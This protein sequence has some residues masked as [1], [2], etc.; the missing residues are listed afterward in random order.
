MG[1]FLEASLQKGFVSAQL[2]FHEFSS[3]VDSLPQFNLELL[4]VS[5]SCFLLSVSR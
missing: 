2:E 1:I 4:A 5:E 3:N